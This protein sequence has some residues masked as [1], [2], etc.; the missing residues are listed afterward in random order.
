[1]GGAGARRHLPMPYQHALT[2][3]LLA[4]IEEHQ[5][6]PLVYEALGQSC[7]WF[8]EPTTVADVMA[9]LAGETRTALAAMRAYRHVGLSPYH[10]GER[11]VNARRQ[12][13]AATRDHNK[14]DSMSDAK[15]AAPGDR[16]RTLPGHN[17]CCLVAPELF[18]A[19]DE[20]NAC[21][22]GRRHRAR[23]T[24]SQGET[25]GGQLPRARRAPDGSL[26][27]QPS[28]RPTMENR[29][30][31]PTGRPTSITSDPQDPRPVPDWAVLRQRQA[32]RSPPRKRFEDGGYP[33]TRATRTCARSL[34]T[35]STSSSRRVI[36]RAEAAAG[37]GHRAAHHPP[38]R[39]EHTAARSCLPA[40]A[41]KREDCC[42][43][44][45][46][47]RGVAPRST[48]GGDRA[49]VDGAVDHAQHIPVRVIAI[50]WACRE[51]GDL[52]R[53]WIQRALI[54]GAQP[55][56]VMPTVAEM[57]AYFAKRVAERR[58]NPGDDR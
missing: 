45:E 25:R 51:D 6:E 8:N 57:T 3:E 33:P 17:R 35:Q 23:R 53:S 34:T 39:L 11:T 21:G 40:F 24:G 15:T 52:F 46:D 49:E 44:G 31:S 29:P 32:A 36:V 56:I 50:R 7:A 43:R 41:P 42:A 9:R 2:G 27:R 54:D 16:R 47:P 22:Q 28:K 30:P 26:T 18:E 37:Y 4:A 14:E 13:P 20:G 48:L 1:M 10:A 38:T 19:D 12:G 5:V 58:V 55:Q